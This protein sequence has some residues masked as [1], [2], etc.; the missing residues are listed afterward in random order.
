M[1]QY[2]EEEEDIQIIEPIMAQKRVRIG[3][4]FAEHTEW[5][6][7]PKDKWI[8]EGLVNMQELIGKKYDACKLTLTISDDSVKTEHEG[9]GFKR[10]IEHQFNI[11]KFPYPDKNSGQVKYLG[12]QNLFQLEA[13]LGFDPVFKVS[14]EIVEPYITKNGNKVAPKIDGVKRSINPDFFNAYFNDDGTPNVDA[15]IGKELYADIGVERSDVYGDKNVI[16][17]FVKEPTAI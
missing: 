13:A 7:K 16:S 1:S 10:T 8:P 14:G 17:R 5:E 12:K 3:V 4:T 9:A 11:V 6:V 2:T 15:W